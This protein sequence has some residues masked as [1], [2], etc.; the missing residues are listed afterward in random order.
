MVR[1]PEWPVERLA[2]ARFLAIYLLRVRDSGCHVLVHRAVTWGRWLGLTTGDQSGQHLRGLAAGQN[3]I[4]DRNQAP[5]S[6]SRP[7]AV[8]LQL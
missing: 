5:V 4:S 3:L 8:F 2:E 1:L 6:T 7:D